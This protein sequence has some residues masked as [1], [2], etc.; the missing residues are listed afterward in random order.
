MARTRVGWGPALS[1]PSGTSS[2]TP[3][4]PGA[5]CSGLG[6][7]LGMSTF[8]HHLPQKRAACAATSQTAPRSLPDRGPHGASSLLLAGLGFSVVRVHA[9]CRGTDA[10]HCSG[11]FQAGSILPG[12]LLDAS[13]GLRAQ[14]AGGK[15]MAQ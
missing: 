2:Q 9:R 7:G 5:A 14:V 10:A 13:G 3:P 12:F 15:A 6:A 8:L 11:S 4:G 1:E